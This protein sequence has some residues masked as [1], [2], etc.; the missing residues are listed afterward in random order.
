MVRKDHNFR[1]MITQ[2]GLLNLK[3]RLVFRTTQ[4]IY[5]FFILN[6]EIGNN[7]CTHGTSHHMTGTQL[8]L[9]AARVINISLS[10]SLSRPGR[11]T[12]H[13][14]NVQKHNIH[15]RKQTKKSNKETARERTEV[16]VVGNTAQS[17]I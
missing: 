14:L 8:L 5:K 15:N 2:N 4:P 7:T 17:A 13:H 1:V 9:L 10:L 3:K 11:S 6:S 12:S 16:N